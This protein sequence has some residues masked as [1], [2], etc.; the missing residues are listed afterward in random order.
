LIDLDRARVAWLDE[1]NIGMHSARNPPA[2]RTGSTR[3][4][5]FGAIHRQTVH[6]LREGHG[7]HPLSDALRSRKDEAGWQC[8][9]HRRT[10]NQVEKMTMAG[11]VAE[12]HTAIVSGSAG[13]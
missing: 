8:A 3:V 11:N 12:G 1:K 9:A 5:G 13:F 2:G 10:R 6:H 4:R 7:G